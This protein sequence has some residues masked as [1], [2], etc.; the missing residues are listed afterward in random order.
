MTP[1]IVAPI[2]EVAVVVIL[3]SAIFLKTLEA[4]RKVF[5]FHF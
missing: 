5:R 2:T 3:I 4:V 1:D